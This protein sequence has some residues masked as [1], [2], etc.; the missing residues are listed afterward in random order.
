MGW[1]KVAIVGVGMT[2]FGE[3]YE[4][5]Y[6]VLMQ[7]AFLE[8]VAS[9]DKG[10]DPKEIQGAWFGACRS[11]LAGSINVGGSSLV[12]D[13]GLKGIHAMRLDS[14]G[15]PEAIPLEMLV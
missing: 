3:L 10:M 6:E 12:G 1:N 5:S 9:V 14:G 11:D 13:I 2:K 4:K 7:E 8:A 15:R